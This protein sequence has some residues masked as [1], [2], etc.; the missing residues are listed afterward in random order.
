MRDSLTP[1]QR[2]VLREMKRGR[3]EREIAR[4]LQIDFSTV[5]SHVK[6]IYRHF[7]V[8]SHVKL[9]VKCFSGQG[10]S[11]YISLSSGPL[12]SAHRRSRVAGVQHSAQAD[13]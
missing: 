3:P 7:R 12:A 4:R 5:H 9:L 10:D 11:S 1:R 13:L 6:A 8:H 2:Q